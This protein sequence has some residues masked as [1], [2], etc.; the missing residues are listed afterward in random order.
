MGGYYEDE[1]TNSIALSVIVGYNPGL[2]L[3][4]VMI[5]CHLSPYWCVYCYELLVA[6]LIIKARW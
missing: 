6:F 2:V 5:V 4:V 3:L 1:L